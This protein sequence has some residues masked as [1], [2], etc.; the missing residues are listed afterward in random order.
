MDENLICVYCAS[1]RQSDGQYRDAAF[2]LGRSL[3]RNGY[4]IICGGGREGSMG[5]LANGA[6]SEKGRVVGVLPRFMQR[7]EWGHGGLTELCLVDDLHTRKQTMLSRSRAVVALPGGTGTLEELLEA[8]TWKRLGL[9]F[10][11]IILVNTLA[12]FDPLLELLERSVS[13]RFMDQR[14]LQMWRVVL[15]PEQVPSALSQAAQWPANARD[16]AAL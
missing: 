7:L 14:H 5:A 10:N 16:F 13:E 12:F 11:P 2:R 3:A 6:L 9:Y 4:G 1:S 15:E 8:M